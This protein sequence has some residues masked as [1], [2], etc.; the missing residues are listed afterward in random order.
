MKLALLVCLLFPS[1]L[2]VPS[3][4]P[5]PLRVVYAPDPAAARA[6]GIASSDMD[7][8]ETRAAIARDLEQRLAFRAPAGSHVTVEDGEEGRL[9]ATVEGPLSAEAAV[10]LHADAAGLEPLRFLEVAEEPDFTAAGTRYDA[11]VE[12]VRTWSLAHP[13]DPLARFRDV[14][15]A[16]GGP[17]PRML[18][19][20]RGPRVG[21]LGKAVP[22]LVPEDPAEDFRAADLAQVEPRSDD[23][24]YPAVGFELREGRQEAF[25]RFTGRIVNRKLAIVVRGK[26]VSA[27]NVNSRLPG[28][29]IVEGHFTEDEVEGLIEAITDAR[30]GAAVRE[31]E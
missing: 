16:Q 19:V 21:S 27:P 15:R 22:L 3:A 12:R 30:V 24:G 31:V 25:G 5:G 23:L 8:K 6:A 14:P 20:E 2:A 1:S 17:L 29:G 7:A 11:E 26:V 13:E 28:A 4:P 9:V 10:A 18:W